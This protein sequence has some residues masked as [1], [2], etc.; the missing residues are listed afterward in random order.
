MSCRGAPYRCSI[1]TPVILTAFLE[2]GQ[3][4]ECKKETHGHA[5]RTPPRHTDTLGHTYRHTDT[6]I[7]AHMQTHSHTDGVDPAP[8]GV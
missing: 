7:G 3:N 4:L 8:L 1:G 2:H 5:N 6:L